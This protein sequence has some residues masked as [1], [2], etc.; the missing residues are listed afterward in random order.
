MSGTT[1]TSR[2]TVVPPQDI[3][4]APCPWSPK[5]TCPSNPQ[6]KGWFQLH[7]LGTLAWSILFSCCLVDG[8]IYCSPHEQARTSKWWGPPF[9]HPSSKPGVG[10]T[11]LYAAAN[12][13]LAQTAMQTSCN[14]YLGTEVKCSAGYTLASISSMEHWE[15]IGMC[16]TFP[17]RFLPETDGARWFLEDSP[18][19][20][21]KVPKSIS[22]SQDSAF[23]AIF[24][25][26]D[27]R[28]RPS[29]V[30][31]AVDGVAKE[32]HHSFSGSTQGD[33]SRRMC[34]GPRAPMMESKRS[35][36][37]QYRNPQWISDL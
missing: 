34:R 26:V 15:M 31:D 17:P 36:D 12:L 20:H 32:L 21:Q 4:E 24:D 16:P 13:A 11:V 3:L 14:P 1:V 10:G 25:I 5:W 6:L 35:K 37:T 22:S 30:E 9:K 8:L 28:F 19:S 29:L 18:F 7:C 27:I 33:L 23:Q 2:R